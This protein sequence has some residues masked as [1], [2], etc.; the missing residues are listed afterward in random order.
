M[1]QHS[2]L[3]IGGLPDVD[4]IVIAGIKNINDKHKKATHE[5]AL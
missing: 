4:F 1:P 5:V 3:Q 2:I